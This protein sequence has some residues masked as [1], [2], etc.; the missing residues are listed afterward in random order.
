MLNIVLLVVVLGMEAGR[1]GMTAFFTWGSGSERTF[2]PSEVGK[3]AMIIAFAKAFSVRLKPVMNVRDLLPLIVYMGIPLL[4]IVAQP[5][6]GTALVYLAVFCI[7]VFVSG[8]NY[9]LILG[10]LACAVV[11]IIPVWTFMNATDSFR[12]MRISSG[13]IPKATRTRRVRSS[14]PA[15]P[16]AAADCGGRAS[17]PPAATPPSAISPTTTRTSSSPSAARALAWWAPVCWCFSTCCCSVACSIWPCACRTPYGS[18]L[19]IGVASM[20]LFHIVE[21]I[22]MV[23]GLLPVTGI[24]LPFMSLRWLQ[25]DHQHD[26]ALAW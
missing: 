13:S 25:H 26:G 19:I 4:L 24:P 16:W 10:V 2:Q 5:D 15:S 6:V 1:G 22:C 11:L 20:L 8:T 21:N 3:I 14:T 12:L 18:Y 23:I 7:M 17:S 9:K